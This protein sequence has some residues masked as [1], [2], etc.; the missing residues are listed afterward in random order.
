MTD[1]AKK[2]RRKSILRSVSPTF[3]IEA[4]GRGSFLSVTFLGILSVKKF[5]HQSVTLATKRESMEIIGD[6]MEI[7]VFE[8]KT[9]EISGE[10]AEIRFIKKKKEDYSN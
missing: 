6:D 7:S 3:R 9:V 8:D 2:E 1:K 5:T 10:I 4:D